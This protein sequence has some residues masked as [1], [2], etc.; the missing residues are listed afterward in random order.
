MGRKKNQKQNFI[1][2]HTHMNTEHKQTVKARKLDASR[3]NNPLWKKNWTIW[4][5]SIETRTAYRIL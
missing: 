1:Q 4:T 2:I 5:L 3:N